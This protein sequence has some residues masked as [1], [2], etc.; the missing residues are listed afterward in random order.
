MHSRIGAM[1]GKEMMVGERSRMGPVFQSDN[2]NQVL[3]R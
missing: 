1:K 3:V 2:D